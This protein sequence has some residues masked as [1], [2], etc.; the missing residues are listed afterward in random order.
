MKDSLTAAIWFRRAP[1]ALGNEELPPGCW[2][3]PKAMV[4]TLREQVWEASFLNHFYTKNDHVI[5]QDR[6]GTRMREAKQK[7]CC[8]L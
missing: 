2:P 4:Q 6:L 1:T 8:F 7:G 5:Y 3:D